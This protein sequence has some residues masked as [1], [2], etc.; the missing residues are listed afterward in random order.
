MATICTSGADVAASASVDAAAPLFLETPIHCGV[1][2]EWTRPGASVRSVYSYAPAETAVEL[3][4]LWRCAC[5]FQLDG[6]VRSSNFP[7]GLSR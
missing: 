3:P 2:M 6:I 7:S 1:L 5:G 4:P